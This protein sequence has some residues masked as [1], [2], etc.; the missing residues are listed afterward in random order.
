MDL[1]LFNLAE[2]ILAGTAIE[3]NIVAFNAVIAWRAK[4][5]DEIKALVD[6]LVELEIIP[7]S[8]AHSPVQLL[9]ISKAAYQNRVTMIKLV[10]E[11]LDMFEIPEAED[12][13][14]TKFNAPLYWF[15]IVLAKARHEAPFKC[16]LKK[17]MGALVDLGI[18]KVQN[19]WGKDE[20][21]SKMTRDTELQEE[22]LYLGEDE[23]TKD[24]IKRKPYFGWRL[25][26]YDVYE[27]T[28]E[29]EAEP[30][31]AVVVVT[32]NLDGGE[33]LGES[34]M[35]GFSDIE[36]RKSGGE[37]G[38][39]EGAG[40]RGA[41]RDFG[42]IIALLMLFV[43]MFS[44]VETPLAFLG[45]IERVLGRVGYQASSIRQEILTLTSS[46]E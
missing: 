46:S 28:E 6:Q 15:A 25:P 42:L 14:Q 45:E 37:R 2:D 3:S 8:A 41:L 12:E 5:Q 4:K 43:I 29:A 27:A 11:L 23:I 40:T 20:W 17:V 39:Q 34:A 26:P 1:D 10:P 18:A 36:D 19:Q 16:N 44:G 31:E 7:E 22:T 35:A 21:I 30:K 9:P 24:L 13:L 32:R 33:E 38:A